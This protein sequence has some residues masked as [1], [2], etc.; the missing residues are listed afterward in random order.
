MKGKVDD[1]DRIIGVTLRKLRKGKRISMKVLAPR[2]GITYQQ[3]QKYENGQNRVTASRL[4]RIAAVLGEP[5][6]RFYSDAQAHMIG[7]PCIPESRSEDTML[8]TYGALIFQIED[9]V[10]RATLI[11]LIKRHVALMKGQC[12]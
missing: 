1:I 5:I 8:R 3:L 11:D 7:K 10:F 9:S 12:D 6:E 2:V 4:L